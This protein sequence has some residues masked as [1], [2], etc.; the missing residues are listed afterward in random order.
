MP[1]VEAYLAGQGDLDAAAAELIRHM[2]LHG[3]LLGSED[4]YSVAVAERAHALEE[5][6][7]ALLA[8]RREASS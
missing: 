4:T 3:T 7:R 8:Q 2:P 1:Q 6:T 5:R